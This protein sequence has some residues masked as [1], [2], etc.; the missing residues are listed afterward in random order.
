MRGTEVPQELIKNHEDYLLFI[1]T[2]VIL[3]LPPLEKS[4][5]KWQSDQDEY[6]RK[7]E[8]YQEIYKMYQNLESYT[9]L[10]IVCFDYTKPNE[11]Y[12]KLIKRLM[13]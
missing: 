9:N 2:L 6:V 12:T 5:T 7:I 11:S 13:E 3:C 10:P 1:G 8:Q 4:Q